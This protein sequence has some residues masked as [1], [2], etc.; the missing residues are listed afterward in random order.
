MLPNLLCYRQHKNSYAVKNVLWSGCGV[1]TCT[2]IYAFYILGN[3]GELRRSVDTKR[4]SVG[5]I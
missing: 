1:V 3:S 4:T 5:E 2:C